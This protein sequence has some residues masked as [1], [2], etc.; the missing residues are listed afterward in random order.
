[1]ARKP[2]ELRPVMTRIPEGLRRRLERSAGKSGRSMNAEIIHRLEESFR[3]EQSLIGIEEL[4]ASVQERAA[5]QVREEAARF[6]T[7]IRRLEDVRVA[8]QALVTSGEDKKDGK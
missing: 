2:Q 7:E 8:L 5:K 6:E 1:M 3:L 4:S